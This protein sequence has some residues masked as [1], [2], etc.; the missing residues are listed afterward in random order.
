MANDGSAGRSN[1]VK[2]QGWYA[3][4]NNIEHLQT[5]DGQSYDLPATMMDSR[6][7]YDPRL[8]S[9]LMKGMI[10]ATDSSLFPP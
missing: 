4:Y 3:G 2:L 9:G 8:L 1:G 6:C 5:A 10:P 7:S